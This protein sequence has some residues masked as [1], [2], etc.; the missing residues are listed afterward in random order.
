MSKLHILIITFLYFINTSYSETKIND[1]VDGVDRGVISELLLKQMQNLII[2]KVPVNKFKNIVAKKSS[3]IVLIYTISEKGKDKENFYNSAMK[4]R[5]TK[6]SYKYGVTCGVVLSS[7]GIVVTTYTATVNSDKYIVAIDSDKNQSDELYGEIELNANTYNAH[8]LKTFPDLNLVFL[9]ID[10]DKSETFEFINLAND[11]F[12]IDRNGNTNHL[13]YNAIAIGKCKGEHFARKSCAFNNKNKFQ[14][15]TTVIGN[16]TY[17]IIEG[18]PTLVLKTP[19]TCDG[20]LPENHGGAILDGNGKLLGI[21]TWLEDDYTMSL[22]LSFAIPSSTIKKC[23]GLVEHNKISKIEMK[24]FCGLKTQPLN[25]VQKNM[26]KEQLKY[27]SS[28]LQKKV[29]D[30]LNNNLLASSFSSINDFIDSDQLGVIV[31]GVKE[32]SIADKARINVGDILFM[33]NDDCIINPKTFCNLEIYSI[34]KSNIMLTL[35]RKNKII[36]MEVRK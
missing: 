17:K 34:D 8:V 3:G 29:K 5:K 9:K 20:A 13:L 32:G 26:L 1:N 21:P 16:I 23:F 35:V 19:L 30:Y 28:S 4:P 14:M 15:L 18:V 11:E 36:T 6:K 27:S 7:D 22:P 33:F 12:L 10:V 31:T 24:S 2:K 25:K